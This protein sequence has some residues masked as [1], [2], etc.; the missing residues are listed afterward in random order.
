MSAP[1]QARAKKAT[2]EIDS[3]DALDRRGD[4]PGYAR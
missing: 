3:D 1:C 4:G 2:R